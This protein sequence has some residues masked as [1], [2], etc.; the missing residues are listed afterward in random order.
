MSVYWEEI[1]E[2]WNIVETREGKSATRTFFD[3]SGSSGALPAFNSSYGSVAPTLFVATITKTKIGKN[4]DK[5]KAVLSYLPKTAELND[6]TRAFSDL[7]RSMQIGGELLAID[8]K[9]S[10]VWMTDL[11]ANTQDIFK[12]IITGTYTVEEAVDDL[13]IASSSGAVNKII[14]HA[15]M[16]NKGTFQGQSSGTWLYLGANFDERRD[17]TG[18]P[19]WVFEHA[20]SF[21]LIPNSQVIYDAANGPRTIGAA[22]WGWRKVWRDDA[23]KWDISNDSPG[24]NETG[25]LYD[26]TP[27]ANVFSTSGAT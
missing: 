2:G 11:E 3:Q 12:R 20:F 6:T 25:Y 24:A 7:D 13:N 22:E 4:S 9:S 1:T 21:R 27:F 17:E 23:G 8:G 10:Y 16:I 18:T 15:G 5:Q 26:F 19:F 14:S